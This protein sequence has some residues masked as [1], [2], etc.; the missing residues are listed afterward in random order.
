MESTPVPKNEEL[1][2]SLSFRARRGATYE[3]TRCETTAA[4]RLRMV[5]GVSD[6]RGYLGF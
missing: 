3:Q 5:L 4:E 1:L 2:A 6:S